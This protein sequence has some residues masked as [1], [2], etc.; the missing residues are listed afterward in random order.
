MSPGSTRTDRTENIYF[1]IKVLV[2]QPFPDYFTIRSD[3]LKGISN[4]YPVP[5]CAGNTALDPGSDF[6]GQLILSQNHS[7]PVVHTA[8]G[9]VGNFSAQKCFDAA[10]NLEVMGK[11]GDFDAADLEYHIFDQALK[12][13]DAALP[14]P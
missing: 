2:T 6:C 5:F 13:L 1:R 10:R 8:K 4:H 7:I 11:A 3:L 9:M 14:G 12:D